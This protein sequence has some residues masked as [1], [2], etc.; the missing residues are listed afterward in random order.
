MRSTRP[1]WVGVISSTLVVGGMLGAGACASHATPEASGTPTLVAVDAS[2]APVV[3]CSGQTPVAL[4]VKSYLSWCAVSIDGAP[5]STA[6]SQTVC[7]AAGHVSVAATPILGFELGP[8]PWHGTTGDRGA[9]D[10]GV[11]SGSD[12]NATS[13]AMAVAA[14]KSTCVYACC[15]FLDGTGCPPPA[16]PCL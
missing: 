7:V 1:V 5:A 2:D 3:T 6:P 9:G 8:A 14:G 13:T 4:T 12:Q 15:P 11:I 16:S 10:P